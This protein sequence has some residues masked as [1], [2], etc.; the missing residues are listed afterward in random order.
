MTR[1]SIKLVH[2]GRFVAEVA[3]E[4]IEDQGGWSPYLSVSDAGKL[5]QVR[6]ALRDGDVKKASMLGRVFELTPVTG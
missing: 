2:E 1:S 4:L 6:R 3:V 5:D